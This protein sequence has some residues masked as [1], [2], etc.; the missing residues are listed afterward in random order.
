M[1]LQQ[2]DLPRQDQNGSLA[3]NKTIST[4]HD[5]EICLFAERN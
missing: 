3:G 2:T 5:K 4:E 1:T